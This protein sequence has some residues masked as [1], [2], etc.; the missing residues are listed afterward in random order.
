MLL[1]KRAVEAGI[2]EGPERLVHEADNLM[3]DNGKFKG[4]KDLSMAIGFCLKY[5]SENPYVK[6]K[7]AQANVFEMRL[8]RNHG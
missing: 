7:E 6:P 8:R 5:I 4:P 1:A 3:V 2:V